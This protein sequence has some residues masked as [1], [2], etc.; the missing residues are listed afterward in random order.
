MVLLLLLIEVLRLLN[1]PLVP[2][3]TQLVDSQ[4]RRGEEPVGEVGTPGAPD[5]GRVLL[6]P[7]HLYLLHAAAAA[8]AE[9]RAE[10]LVAHVH[11]ALATLDPASS[12]IRCSDIVAL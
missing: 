1:H 4:V 9:V 8:A 11:V 3:D 12:C 6:P 5:P 2:M 7:H 10:D